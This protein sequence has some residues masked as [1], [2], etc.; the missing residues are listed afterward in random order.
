MTH[1]FAICAYEKSPY[2]EECIRSVLNQTVHAEVI[3][4]T[5]TPNDHIR[6]L[7]DRYRIP[8]HVN[9][10]EKGITQDWNYACSLAG[11]D[12]VTIAHQDDLYDPEYT[13][14]LMKYLGKARQP[15]LFFTDYRELR[16]EQTV[17]DN[18]LLRIKRFLLRPL[19]PSFCWNSRF[20]RRRV[21][22]LGSPICCPSVAFV[23]KNCPDKIFQ[24]GFRSDEDWQAWERLSREKGAFVY[25]PKKLMTH[26]I[27]EDSETSRIIRD[28]ARDREDYLM[29]RRFWPEPVARL[30]TKLYASSQKSN[31]LSEP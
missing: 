2:L 16:G 5:S 1:T 3:L 6:G 25:A 19:Q 20:I 23:K 29:F 17:C 18:R 8:M 22:S 12:T 28:H 26:R 10:G 21:L 9:S 30:L 7:C 13:E 24:A 31:E 15:I 27:H 14:E 11:T 4:A